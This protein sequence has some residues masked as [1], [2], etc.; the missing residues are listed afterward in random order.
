MARYPQPPAVPEDTRPI[1]SLLFA[2][3]SAA[4][5][6]QQIHTFNDPRSSRTSGEQH[7][8]RTVTARETTY[9]DP[10]RTR[11]ED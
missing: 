11:D 7:G 10:K 1:G 8:I 6:P 2:D 9:W 4:A 3:P 5:F